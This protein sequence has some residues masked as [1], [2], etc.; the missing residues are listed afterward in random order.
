MQTAVFT[1][2][3]TAKDL[4]RFPEK[5][6]RSEVERRQSSVEGLAWTLIAET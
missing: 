6:L 4:Q 5:E 1:T 3:E 2:K